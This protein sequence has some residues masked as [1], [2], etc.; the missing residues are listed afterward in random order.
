MYTIYDNTLSMFG[1]K[2]KAEIWYYRIL[3]VNIRT[4]YFS[5]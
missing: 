2:F 3:D 5:F 1:N 4:F